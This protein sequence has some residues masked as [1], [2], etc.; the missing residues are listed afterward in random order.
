[1]ELL[2][3][4]PVKVKQQSGAGEEGSEPLLWDFNDVEKA[5]NK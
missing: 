2:M 4:W 5:V 1:M 3:E